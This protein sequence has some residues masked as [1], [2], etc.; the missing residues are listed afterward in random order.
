MIKTLT[1]L[2]AVVRDLDPQLD[3]AEVAAA[4]RRQYLREQM[5]PQALRA[6]LRRA[7]EEAAWLAVGLP[8][9][10][11]RLLDKL[12]HDGIS[13]ELRHRELPEFRAHLD[14]IA[15]RLCF[16][17]ILLSFSLM[18]T[19][20]VISSALVQGSRGLFF[21]RLPVLEIGF[22]AA[23][24]LFLGLIWAIVRSGRF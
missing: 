9:N 16:A 6:R 2:E 3:L 7:W 14:Q 8:R 22:G 18:M 21:W 20:L 17:I 19:G 12:A 10:L 24:V 5:R 4:F 11:N 1:T 23:A 15:N 13:L